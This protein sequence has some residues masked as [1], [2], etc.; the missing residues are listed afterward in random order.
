VIAIMWFSPNIRRTHSNVWGCVR[1][2]R[3]IRNSKR[4]RRTIC[5]SFHIFIQSVSSSE[6]IWDEYCIRKSWWRILHPYCIQNSSRCV[7]DRYCAHNY[8]RRW[9][10]T[11]D[12]LC[13]ISHLHSIRELVRM[14]LRWILHM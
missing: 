12:D 8:K 14:Y 6:C 13:I 5:A 10:S 2:R 1:N 7:C 4:R 11:N 3:C 9:A